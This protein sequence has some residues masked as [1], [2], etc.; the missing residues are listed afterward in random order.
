MM[1]FLRMRKGISARA[2]S[3][4][5]GLSPSYLSKV[6]SGENSLS[7]KAFASLARTLE[8]SPQEIVFIVR[9]LGNG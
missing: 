6:E 3:I 4:E 5:A 1:K 2:A 8:M 9:H 7:L